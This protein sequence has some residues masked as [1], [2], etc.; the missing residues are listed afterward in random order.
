MSRTYE[1]NLAG[2]V[3]DRWKVLHFWADR[4]RGCYWL[5]RCTC[6]TVRPVDGYALTSGR[7]QGCGCL[8]IIMLRHRLS[9]PPY[10]KHGMTDT[11]I[12]RIWQTMLNRCRNPRVE[13]YRYYGARG[14][15][16]CE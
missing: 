8:R 16:V 2:Q 9:Q 6:G 14:I 4:R 15:T 3:F 7:A 1:V 13:G 11:P 12:Y 10:R 5:C